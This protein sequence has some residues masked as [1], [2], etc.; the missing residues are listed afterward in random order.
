M[1]DCACERCDSHRSAPKP[2]VSSKLARGFLRAR[3]SVGAAATRLGF[4]LLS[5][6]AEA[7][8][9]GVGGRAMVRYS[10]SGVGSKGRQKPAYEQG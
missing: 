4:F 8:S 5:N 9:R 6:R 2:R 7:L 1:V 3:A 10:S